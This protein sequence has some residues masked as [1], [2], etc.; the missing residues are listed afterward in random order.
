MIFSVH[1]DG[2]SIL[3]D[4]DE[5][6]PTAHLCNSQWSSL[7]DQSAVEYIQSVTN[8]GYSRSSILHSCSSHIR[9]CT[10]FQFLV[11]DGKRV[12]VCSCKYWLQWKIWCGPCCW[13]YYIL[14]LGR[15]VVNSFEYTFDFCISAGLLN[16]KHKCSHCRRMLKLSVAT[17]WQCQCSGSCSNK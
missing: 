3:L 12:E 14:N 7:F 6:C 13:V 9:Q 8:I 17:I 11:Q 1:V 2:Q 5:R 16:K 4:K 10:V 15:F